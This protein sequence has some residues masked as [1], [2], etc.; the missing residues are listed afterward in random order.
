MV[1]RENETVEFKSV[2][3]EDIKKEVIAFANTDGGK[4]YIGVADD[5][6]TV[7]VE[8]A[9]RVILRVVNMLRDSVRPDVTM[10]VR[11]AIESKD[12]MQVV[13]VDVCRGTNRPYYL[14]AKGLRPEGVYVRRGTSAVPA[15][16]ASIR[17]M[18]KDTDGDSF[19]LMRSLDQDLTFSDAEKEFAR[20][21]LEFGTPQKQSL[22]LYNRDGIYTNLALLLSDQCTHTVKVAVFQGSDQS[23]F[24]DRRE[25]SGSILRQLGDVYSFIDLCNPISATFEGLL[26]ID[27]RAYPETAVREALLNSLV[28]R[29]Y[30]FSASTLISIYSDRIEFVSVGGLVR[31][32][33]LDDIMMGVSICR[34]PQLA[35]VF[36]RLKLIEAYGTGMKKIFSAYEGT[37]VRPIVERSSNAF[38]VVLPSITAKRPDTLS[39][40]D[41]REKNVLEIV[42]EKKGASREDVQRTLGVGASTASRILRS[43]VNDGRLIMTGSARNTKY[44][45]P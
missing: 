8:N 21:D 15:T 29:D 23:V 12:G 14:A 24:K 5:G 18:I 31:G 45:I 34:N 20:R 30:S 2:V 36:Y 13:V 40:P 32:I 7:G 27:T 44:L 16:D 43:M 1:D 19:E 33:E 28:H 9:D 11:Y 41:E 26:R 38:K 17:A 6:T 37:G 10:F 22:M 4:I 42:R 35:N 3:V 39:E 25:F